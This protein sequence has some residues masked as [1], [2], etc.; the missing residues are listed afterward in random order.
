MATFGTSQMCGYAA[1]KG[2]PSEVRVCGNEREA[3]TAG[4]MTRMS[5]W[6]EDFNYGI[7]T[8]DNMGRAT[9]TIF[10]A[11]QWKGGHRDV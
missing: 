3:I 5:P 11:S 4:N 9:L 7:T 2:D 10:S 6:P 1:W 8:F